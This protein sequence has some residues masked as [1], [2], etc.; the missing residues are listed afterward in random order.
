VRKR[1]ESMQENIGRGTTFFL[2]ERTR[3]ERTGKKVHVGGKERYFEIKGS[4][5]RNGKGKNKKDAAVEQLGDRRSSR[6]RSAGNHMLT[7]GKSKERDGD[8][9]GGTE[10]VQILEKGTWLKKK[11]AVTER[12]ASV[13]SRLAEP[14]RQEGGAF[15]SDLRA[16]EPS[17]GEGRR[18]SEG[19]NDLKNNWSKQW[20]GIQ[21]RERRKRKSTESRPGKEKSCPSQGGMPF[22]EWIEGRR[23]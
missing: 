2:L 19:E 14:R 3:Q 11:T 7:L 8:D 6:I 21:V 22:R 4:S 17:T 20:G 12:R 16:V 23:I 13:C 15:V 1:K 10:G 18:K 9:A 5:N